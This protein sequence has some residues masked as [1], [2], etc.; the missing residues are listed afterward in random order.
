MRQLQSQGQ[1]R[2]TATMWLGRH[3][4]SDTKDAADRG[5]DLPGPQ[6]AAPLMEPN[7]LPSAG[8]HQAAS[9]AKDNTAKHCCLTATDGT[10]SK[11]GPCSGSVH[12]THLPVDPPA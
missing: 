11:G 5:W 12:G 7:R 3:F 10:D 6:L 8:T 4:S 1:S 2:S 9:K